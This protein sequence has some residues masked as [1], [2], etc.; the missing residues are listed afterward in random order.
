MSPAELT[1]WIEASGYSRKELA[2]ILGV[3]NV[4]VS[5]WEHGTRDIPSFLH[6]ALECLEKKGGKT[7]KGNTKKKTGKDT[8]HERK[9]PEKG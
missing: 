9:H 6:L 4:S 7:N 5:R 2:E 1:E 3:S 8:K